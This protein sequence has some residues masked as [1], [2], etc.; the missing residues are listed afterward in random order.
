MRH[1]RHAPG[2]RHVPLHADH[3]HAGDHRRRL[4]GR[5]TAAQRLP[6][7]G[8]VLRRDGPLR[9]PDRLGAAAAGNGRRHA[10]RR[11]LG[12]LRARRLLQR[13]TGRSAPPAA[14]TTTLDARTD[15][16][17]G[18]ALPAG[19][20]PAGVDGGAAARRGGRRGRRPARRC[21]DRCR[22]S[23][24]RFGTASTSPC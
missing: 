8:D 24:W 14:R 3:R 10:R 23:T 21:R 20:R 2:Q 17:A 19:R 6:E 16:T 1:A 4:D 15:R 12:A 5:R 18:A 22:T 13:R 11:L 9:R 7:Q